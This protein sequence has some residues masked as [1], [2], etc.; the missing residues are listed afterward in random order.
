MMSSSE[1]KFPKVSIIVVNWNGKNDTIE[2]IKSLKLLDYPN[3]DIIV[4][5]NG[6]TDGSQKVLKK[7]FPDITLIELKENIGYGGAANEG[8]KLAI[9][10]GSDY[11]FPINNDII[12]DKNLLKELVRVAESDPKIGMVCPKIL[13]YDRPDWICSIAGRVDL[14]FMI[15]LPKH[16]GNIPD[17][18]QYDKIMEVDA[19]GIF[20][21]KKEVVER[22]G[23]FDPNYFLYLEDF[24][25][26]IRVRRAGYRIIYVPTAI[27]YHKGS[28]SVGGPSSPIPIYYNTRNRF[29]LISKNFG[30]FNLIFFIV[31]FF[32]ITFPIRIIYYMLVL[33]NKN[34]LLSFI[35]GIRDGL[36]LIIKK[37]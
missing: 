12:L 29:L 11:V 32:T 10:R 24:D 1:V 20:L 9:K 2:C 8:I 30:K 3:Y 26:C 21:V 28:A 33:R 25:W 17:R 19:A 14:K 22:V 36:K 35:K 31:L 18:G 34:Y 7:K 4:V 15:Q 16:I 13:W 23:M 37:Q 5:D 27:M 6:S